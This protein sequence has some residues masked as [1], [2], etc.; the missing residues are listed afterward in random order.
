VSAAAPDCQPGDFNGDGHAD[1]AV[2]EPMAGRL[3]S[4][5]PTG[6]AATLADAV[7]PAVGDRRD[8]GVRTFL[9]AWGNAA[10]N[11]GHDLGVLCV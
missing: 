11:R 10:V 2:G 4:A 8:D 9:T 5:A 3:S 6:A 1:V 7:S